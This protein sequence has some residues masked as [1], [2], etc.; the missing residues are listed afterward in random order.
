M[1]TSQTLFLFLFFKCFNNC[2]DGSQD[3]LGRRII[4]EIQTILQKN[5]QTADVASDYW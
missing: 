1:G 4:L 2:K 3:S 5:L